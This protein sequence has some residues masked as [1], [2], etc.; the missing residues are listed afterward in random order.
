MPMIGPFST[1]SPSSPLRLQGRKARC[2][3]GIM[4]SINK[5]AQRR[6]VLALSRGLKR[7]AGHPFSV[8]FS[9]I[10][11]LALPMV[12]TQVGQIAM[13]TTDLALIGRIGAEAVAG[14]ALASRV[15]F[16]SLTFGAGLM[17]AIAPLAA[18]AFGAA[19]PAV[20]RHSVRMG[21]WAALLVSLPI[22]AFPLW[23]E[24]LLLALGQAPD[25][26]WRAQQYLSGLAW[27]VAPAL[28]FLAIRSFMGAVTRPAP[29]LWITLAAIP[30]NTLLV[31]LLSY[32]KLGLPRLEL[33]GAGLATSLVNCA[34]FLAGL[35]FTTMRRPFRDYCVVEH[36]WRFDWPV[37]RQLIVIGIPISIAFVMELSISSAAT[38]LVGLISIEALA[39]HQIA[40]QVAAILFTIASGI[41][42]AAAV[43]V[44]HAAAR[45]D[46]PGIKRAGVAAALLGVVIAATLTVAVI[47]ARFELASLFLGPS[48]SNA[49][50][51]IGLTASLLLVGASCF[52]TGAVHI[53]GSSSLRGL[54]DTGAPLLY[55]AIGYG[56]IGLS[57]SYLLGLKVGLGA[58]GVWIGLSIGKAVCAVLVI[59]RF[60]LLASRLAV[61]G[62]YSTTKA[63]VL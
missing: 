61:Q 51:N 38:L 59:L 26:A 22:M 56:L 20:V 34:M 13:M 3:T 32:G 44:G 6:S 39:A 42:M 30:V 55:T 62:R 15:Y 48:A 50:A 19:N 28:W 40:F 33:F 7:F 31:Y 60:Q 25:A 9:E 17:A 24:Q 57:L 47:A 36:L 29:A 37:M 12:L 10:A 23:G 53:I 45:N 11:K 52:I 43:R 49:G 14:A 58:I 27:G 63:T 8:E 16:V 4:S 35:W 5:M 18:Q 2:K 21:L 41:G 1:Q 46:G 54:M